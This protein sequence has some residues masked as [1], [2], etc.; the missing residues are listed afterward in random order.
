MAISAKMEQRL[1]WLFLDAQE[2]RFEES[3]SAVMRNRL[4]T[5]RRAGKPS[6]LEMKVKGQGKIRRAGDS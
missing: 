1:W 4:S 6:D 2:M 3:I 5:F